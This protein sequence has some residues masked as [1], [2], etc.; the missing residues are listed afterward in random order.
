M[1]KSL[2]ASPETERFGHLNAL[3]EIPV[4]LAS[5]ETRAEPPRLSRLSAPFPQAEAAL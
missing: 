1:K 2:E 3:A 5:P 4:P